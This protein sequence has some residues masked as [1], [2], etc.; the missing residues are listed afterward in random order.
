MKR[1]V[2]IALLS[3]SVPALFADEEADFYT[4]QFNNAGTVLGQLGVVK[5][6]VNQDIAEADSFYA[7]A[8]SRLLARYP[9]VKS[10]QERQ[11]ADD[12]AILLVQELGKDGYVEAG[13]NV[14]RVIKTFSNAL[15]KSEALIALGRMNATDFLP[16]V[17][18][19]LVDATTR[20]P[21][22]RTSGERIAYGAITALANYKDPSGYIPV[23]FA[24]NGWYQSWVKKAANE[25][26]PLLAEDPAEQLTAVIQDA[27]YTYDQK[28]LALR[29]INQS[30]TSDENKIKAA[31]TGLIIGW[32]GSS[33]SPDV[34]Y[35]QAQ[36]RKTA[37]HM[38]SAYGAGE[39]EA[40][41][42]NYL[43]W[44]YRHAF[45]D[46]EQLTAVSAFSKLAS[47][48]AVQYLGAYTT[49]INDKKARGSLAVQDERRI[50]ALIAGLGNTHNQK[51]KGYLQMVLS[52][53]WTNQ[54]HK[55]TQEA[56]DNL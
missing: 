53:N 49:E 9:N 38:I 23:F 43:N 33:A 54:I 17:S 12:M 2:I 32:A 26:L 45:D 14:W 15:V 27:A 13:Q 50:R 34:R 52:I 41:I 55:I 47:D 51:A 19:A 44:S 10:A 56:V 42:L 30:D 22:N 6:V 29:T 20:G 11:A 31:T 35:K 25:T 36:I 3:F 28:S 18:Q 16:H 4:E 46:E 40:S 37:L 39:D 7:T 5:T 21:A 48:E 1:L 8:L 24:A